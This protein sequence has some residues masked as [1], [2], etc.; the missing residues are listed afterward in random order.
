MRAPSIEDFEELE[1][2]V[3]VIRDE[4]INFLEVVMISTDP[5]TLAAAAQLGME[6]LKSLD[7]K[8]DPDWEI[9]NFTEGDTAA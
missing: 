6:T 7:S 3:D 9:W 5:K 1:R 2:R 4:V 8:R